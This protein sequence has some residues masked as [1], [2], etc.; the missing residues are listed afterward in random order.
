MESAFFEGSGNFYLKSDEHQHNLNFYIITREI[1]T[2]IREE[3][4]KEEKPSSSFF[5]SLAA[6]NQ[7][8]HD[9]TAGIL[10]H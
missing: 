3:L 9:D 10:H 6:K 2:S 1:F 7:H 4:D 5:R 8:D